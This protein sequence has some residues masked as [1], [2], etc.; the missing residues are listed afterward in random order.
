MNSLDDLIRDTLAGRA[1]DVDGLALAATPP[2]RRSGRRWVAV[3]TVVAVAAAILVAVVLVAPW[4]GASDRNAGPAT[5]PTPPAGMQWVSYHGITLTVPDSW[6][7]GIFFCTRPDRSAVRIG[8]WSG[9][10][11]A[12]NPKGVVTPADATVLYLGSLSDQTPQG[13]PTVV[14][15][16]P[17]RRFV[18]PAGESEPGFL[19]YQLLTAG[20]VI[21][22]S[23]PGMTDE[24]ILAGLR[25]TPVDDLGCAATIAADPI[26][27]DTPAGPITLPTPTAVTVCDYAPV[28]SGY[29]GY[30]M[31]SRV[32]TADERTA[33]VA[34]I[35]AALPWS[36]PPTD[37]GQLQADSL[38]YQFT[39]ADGSTRRVS[40][41][42]FGA[43]MAAS[44]GDRRVAL[45]Y[46]APVPRAWA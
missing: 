2:P 1:H 33:L 13:D 38:I 34:A 41:Q 16:Q 44:N 4:R 29:G 11:C 30:L 19:Q 46:D 20:V 28:W 27:A 45:P 24:N 37:N 39:M 14:E 3:G 32:L 31:G 22:I 6:A 43:V 23:G 8:E 15:G 5:A 36:D 21:Q 12:A 42:A 9:H 17:A 7:T 10:S 25:Y 40:A 26:P 18:Y 35:D